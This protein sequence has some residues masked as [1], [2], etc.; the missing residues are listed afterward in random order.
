MHQTYVR[1]IC[2][3][4]SLNPHRQET[5][6]TE[7]RF[8]PL[9]HQGVK[10]CQAMSYRVGIL[11]FV[12]RSISLSGDVRNF[13]IRMFPDQC[14]IS[15]IP[16]PRSAPQ[17][18]ASTPCMMQTEPLSTLVV[19]RRRAISHACEKDGRLREKDGSFPFSMCTNENGN[20][21]KSFVH[22]SILETTRF[23]CGRRIRSVPPHPERGRQKAELNSLSN[24][25]E[26]HSG[27]GSDL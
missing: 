2:F 5:P 8:Y 16:C 9:R 6:G 17:M 3:H 13:G 10:A 11:R 15:R 21:L 23:L 1:A 12:S 24:S 26:R 7:T 27:R 19:S 18:L 25:A 20:L 4:L 14:T 22:T